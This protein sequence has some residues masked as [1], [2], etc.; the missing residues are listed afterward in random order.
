MSSRTLVFILVLL[1]DE[2]ES[3]TFARQASFKGNEP[4]DSLRVVNAV[5]TQIDRLKSFPNVF[6]LATSN[7]TDAVG[8]FIL[9]QARN[10]Y[11]FSF[12]EDEAF[13]DRADLVT[14]IDVPTCTA[15]YSVLYTSIQQFIKAN[16]LSCEKKN[17]SC[18]P[19]FQDS[20]DSSMGQDSSQEFPN[21]N[22]DSGL[23][24]LLPIDSLQ[25]FPNLADPL[26]KKLHDTCLLL[27]Q[28]V[29]NILRIIPG[30]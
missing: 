24:S 22:Q 16:I 2:V 13:L 30:L 26:S 23:L 15:I 20:S 11:L 27:E 18:L 8:K 21:S 29:K 4:G 10:Y 9:C 5:L 28:K 12:A 7:M 3:I 19:I 14:L 17:A 25:M 6:I 1:I